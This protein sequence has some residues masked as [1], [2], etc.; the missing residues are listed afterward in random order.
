MTDINT[1][2]S[3]EDLKIAA[4]VYGPG[5]K[6]KK[7]VTLSKGSGDYK[8]SDDKLSVVCKPCSIQF[9]K[10]DVVTYHVTF[11]SDGLELDF[12]IKAVDGALQFNGG[13]HFFVDGKPDKGSVKSKFIPR[14]AATG[15]IKIDGTTHDAKGWSTYTMVTQHYPQNVALWNFLHFHNATDSLMLYQFELP[16]GSVKSTVSQGCLVLNNKIVA[17]TMDNHTTFHGTFKDDFQSKYSIPTSLTHEWNGK[18]LKGEPINIKMNLS[19]KHCEDK[20]DIL[21]ELPYLVRKIIQTFITAPYVYQWIEETVVDVTIAGV[22]TQLKGRVMHENTFL[23]E[24]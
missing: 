10:A 15:T 22:T 6:P 2:I 3:T 4:R 7:S 18:T 17:V 20:V 9:I 5:G 16:K 19:L 11:D 8:V 21:G 12:T 14:A 1:T 13:Q 24:L 23:L